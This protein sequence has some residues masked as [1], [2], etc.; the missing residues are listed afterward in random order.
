M[1]IFY[2]TDLF[3]VFCLFGWFGFSSQYANFAGRNVTGM[4]LEVANSRGYF[5]M[6]A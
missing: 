2:K 6:L 4:D 1:L 3:G 5:K